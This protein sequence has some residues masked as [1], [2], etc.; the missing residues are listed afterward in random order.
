LFGKP[1]VL[2]TA[3][4]C[5]ECSVRDGISLLNGNLSVVGSGGFGGLVI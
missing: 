1:A 4:K 3:A 5:W 2:C